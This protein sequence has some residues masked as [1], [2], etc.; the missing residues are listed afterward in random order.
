MSSRGTNG[1]QL[2]LGERRL[3]DRYPIDVDVSYKVV[4]T[5]NTGES[6]FGRVVN[7][8]S[9]GLIAECQ[10]SLQAGLDVELIVT[11]PAQYGRGA[12]LKLHATGHTVR[13]DGNC[14]ALRLD[15]SAFRLDA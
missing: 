1:V 9:T 7:L 15:E 4:G 3:A 11:W 13:T 6:G 5:T 10:P 2:E 8:S 12:G 14:T